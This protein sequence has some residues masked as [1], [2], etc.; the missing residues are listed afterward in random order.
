VQVWPSSTHAEF[1]DSEDQDRDPTD[2]EIIAVRVRKIEPLVELP[3]IRNEAVTENPSRD[4]PVVTAPVPAET[5][6]KGRG[7]RRKTPQLDLTFGDTETAADAATLVRRST[8]PPPSPAILML[9][10][11]PAFGP[12]FVGPS[13]VRNVNAVGMR[14]GDL[15]IFHHYGAGDL[16]TEQ[17]LFSLANMFEPGHFDMQR[18][19]AFQTAGLV[20]FLNLPAALDGPVAFELFLNTAQRLAE[21]LQAELLADPKTPLDSASI[22]RLRR[23]AALFANH[24]G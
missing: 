16:R 13:I 18:I 7:K 15:Q 23:T 3:I 21:G 1:D 14:H 5:R 8:L 24:E 17:A 6:G 12:A 11:R 4:T 2:D 22:D 20:M 10:L 9:Y 19:E